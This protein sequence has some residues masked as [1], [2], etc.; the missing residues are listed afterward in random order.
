MRAPLL[1]RSPAGVRVRAN[2]VRTRSHLQVLESKADD[3]V[4]L[5]ETT[6]L[7]KKTAFAPSAGATPTALPAEAEADARAR[8]ALFA[9]AGECASRAIYAAA[10]GLCAR[11]WG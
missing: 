6:L 8:G 2:G 4:D 11:A 7:T 5:L 9:P 10:D 3:A 1:A